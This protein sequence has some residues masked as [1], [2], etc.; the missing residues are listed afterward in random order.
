MC[1]DLPQTN[2]LC[3]YLL[4]NLSPTISIQLSMLNMQLFHTLF[5]FVALLR[6]FPSAKRRRVGSADN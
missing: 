6:N 4:F 3:I 5:I 1:L 2:I